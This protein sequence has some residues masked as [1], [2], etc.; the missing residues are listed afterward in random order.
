MQNPI[1]RY[2]YKSFGRK[3]KGHRAGFF[4]VDLSGGADE[5]M[6]KS[7]LY[8][9]MRFPPRFSAQVSRNRVD[10]RQILRDLY[11]ETSF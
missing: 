5:A 7:G 2:K 11:M 6:Y 10:N 8:I 1:H 4:E 3:E 9:E